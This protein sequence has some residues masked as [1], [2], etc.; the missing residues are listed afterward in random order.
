MKLATNF[1]HRSTSILERVCEHIPFRQERREG[2]KWLLNHL[3]MT[4]VKEGL[5]VKAVR[6]LVFIKCL[7][8]TPLL[9][10]EKFPIIS[11]PTRTELL[12]G[13]LKES[14]QGGNLSQVKQVISMGEHITVNSN[15]L[16]QNL[17]A[18]KQASC[19][20][21]LINR[22]HIALDEV[23]ELCW[24]PFPFAAF[25]VFTFQMMLRVFPGITSETVKHF[26]CWC[27]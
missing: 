13:L 21:W 5:I 3:E 12:V 24:E 15:I 9:I 25:D 23:L 8:A 27:D 16:L 19:A 26:R 11:E 2:V 22:L 20:E 4:G 7:L 17:L 1:H 14:V 6:H 18:N 10:I